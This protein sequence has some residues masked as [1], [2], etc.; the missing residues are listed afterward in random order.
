MT[1][2]IE[3]EGKTDSQGLCNSLSEGSVGDLC[4]DG[5]IR[6]EVR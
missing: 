3:K 4:H 5:L 1:K 6:N 2:E